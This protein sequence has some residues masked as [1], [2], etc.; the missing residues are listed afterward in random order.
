MG[1]PCS[2]CPTHSLLSR[3][4]LLQFYASL[5]GKLPTYN[6]RIALPLT[7]PKDKFFG[8]YGQYGQG[9]GAGLG[10]PK[11]SIRRWSKAWLRVKTEV[12]WGGKGCAEKSELRMGSWIPLS[13]PLAPQTKRRLKTKTTTW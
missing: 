12:G 6:T 9:K 13:P 11:Q 3:S 4:P 7:S 2:P 10:G 1:L 8:Q 5:E